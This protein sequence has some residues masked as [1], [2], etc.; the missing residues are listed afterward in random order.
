MAI[1][2]IDNTNTG[3][4]TFRLGKWMRLNL[5]FTSQRPEIDEKMEF[6]HIF[7]DF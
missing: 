6:W 4:K 2:D 1:S 3:D 7:H 5:I